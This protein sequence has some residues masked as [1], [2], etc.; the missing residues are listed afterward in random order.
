MVVQ[1]VRISACHAEGRGFESRPLRQYF[2]RAKNIS[3][4]GVVV[5]LVRIPACHAGGRGFESRP[6]RQLFQNEVSEGFWSIRFFC[7]Y[8]PKTY[9]F[10]RTCWFVR[11]IDLLPCYHYLFTTSL[12]SIVS[13]ERIFAKMLQ[14]FRTHKRWMMFIAMIFIIPSFVV[15][16]IYSYNRM[17]DSEN[18]IAK[19]GDT[20]ITVEDFNNAKRN[21]LDNLR[22]QMGSNFNPNLLDT[23]EAKVSILAGLITDRVLSLEIAQSYINVSEADAVNLIKSA[24]AFQRNGKFS[25]EAYKQFLNATGK[26]DEYF[27]Y[28]LRRDMAREILMNSVAQTT[29]GSNTVATRIHDLLSEERGIRTFTIKPDTFAKDVKVTDEE[30]KAYYE[31]NKSLFAVDESVDIEYVVLSPENYKDIKASDEDAKTFYEQNQQRF[32][33]PEQR[34]ASH[35]LITATGDKADEA[36]KKADDLYAQL[37]ADPKKFAALAK[38]NSKDPGSARN[39]GD[40]GFFPKGMMVPEFEKAVFSAKKGDLVA[41]VKTDFGYHI[42][43]VT[44]IKPAQV[45]PMADVRK[46]IDTLYAQQAAMQMFAEDAENFSNMVYEQSESLQPVVEKFGLKI[47]KAQNITR[48][49]NDDV[50][51]PNVV[52]ALYSFDVLEDKRNSN[53]IE[54]APNTLLS[55]R[56]VKHHPKSTE[57]FD[58][59]KDEIK[60]ALTKQK[61]GEMAKAE[62][63]KLLA[64]LEKGDKAAVTFGKKFTIS[65]EKPESLTFDVVNVALRPL[66]QT[67]PTYTGLQTVDGSYVIVNVIDNKM[68]PITP[69]ELA[70]RKAELAQ[71]YSRPEQAAFIAALEEKFGVEILKEEYKADYK[72]SEE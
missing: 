54:I 17:N 41:P 1:L 58:D 50:I 43:M 31:K 65:R 32:T 11:P 64:K 68:T 26:S 40:L 71:L 52:E 25:Q 6:L 69:E 5:Q 8:C 16:G 51:N 62:G 61:M 49:H 34:R 24:P 29:L 35:I 57:A 42:I 23:Q 30:M 60:T 53:A 13:F 7:I 47:Q 38:E 12:L 36:K 4:A 56:V 33:T 27:V 9:L 2:L 18:D 66:S 15:T 48:S 3:D 44:D 28:E 39:G 55:A 72:P 67:L 19:V 59:V 10:V 46:E 22:R 20:T 63:E 37:K 70:M 21:Y 14:A 45:K